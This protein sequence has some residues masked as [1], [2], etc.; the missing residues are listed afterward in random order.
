MYMHAE[1]SVEVYVCVCVCVP[2]PDLTPG[3]GYSGPPA[4]RLDCLDAAHECN[5]QQ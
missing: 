5:L 2:F 1:I 3:S 4:L